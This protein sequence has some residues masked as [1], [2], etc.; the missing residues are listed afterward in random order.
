MRPTV[1]TPREIAFF[2]PSKPIPFGRIEFPGFTYVLDAW[3]DK[4][5]VNPEKGT[6]WTLSSPLS[7]AP[8]RTSCAYD[9]HTD[10]AA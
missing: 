9:A 8:E 5:G 4:K 6:K 1:R 10:R 2:H 7:K 3:T